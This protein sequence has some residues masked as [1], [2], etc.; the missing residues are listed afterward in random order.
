MARTGYGK[1]IIFYIYSILTSKITLQ[2]IPLN[3]LGD[4]QQHNIQKLYGSNPCLLN[5][6]SKEPDLLPRIIAGEFM[7]VLLGP[8][9]VLTKGF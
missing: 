9:Q 8:E 5:V 3:K 6:K 4:K 1:S 7:Y 2:I